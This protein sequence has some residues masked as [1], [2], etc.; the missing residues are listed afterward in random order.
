MRVTTAAVSTVSRMTGSSDTTRA[1]ERLVGMPRPC[2]ASLARYS[3]TDERNTARPSPMREY[4]V[5]PAPLS[6]SSQPPAGPRT[7]P[8]WPAHTPNW[9]P[10]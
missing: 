8:S 3:R 2:M 10:L 9:W 4:G 6:C 7:S 1:R 5:M